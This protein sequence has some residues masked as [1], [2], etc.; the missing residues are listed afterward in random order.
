MIGLQDRKFKSQDDTDLRDDSNVCEM[1][2]EPLRRCGPSSPWGSDGCDQHCQEQHPAAGREPLA[3]LESRRNVPCN[4]DVR[5]QRTSGLRSH[6]PAP[7]SKA[8]TTH[9]PSPKAPTTSRMG[10]PLCCSRNFHSQPRASGLCRAGTE[11]VVGMRS[12]ASLCQ[13]LT[14]HNP[15][16]SCWVIYSSP[17]PACG[18][19]HAGHPSGAPRRSSCGRTPSG[20][21]SQ[22]G[23][24]GPPTSCATAYSLTPLTAPCSFQS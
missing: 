12:P 19:K 8:P 7:Y 24:G 10:S 1:Q 17:V 2:L 16:G 3:Q 9:V 5:F 6:S 11:S 20:C 21:L 23:G 22:A 4:L 15:A 18:V 13:T 14:C